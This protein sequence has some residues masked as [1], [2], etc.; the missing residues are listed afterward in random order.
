M[1]LDVDGLLKKYTAKGVL[2]DTNLLV[3]LLVGSVNKNRITRFKRTQAFTTADFDLLL[4]LIQ[5]L[6]PTIISTSHI[7]SQASDLADLKGEEL[8][9]VRAFMKRLVIET[10]EEHR[11]PAKELAA[12]PLFARL[13][14]GDAGIATVCAKNVL[15]ITTDV[16]LWS[17]IQT[18]GLD[19]INFNHI[20]EIGRGVRELRS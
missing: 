14:L 19:A 3:L 6:G 5:H 12:H 16:E 11:D 2:I 9:R 13:G 18:V 10:I 17:E 15:V 4:N 8:G 20:S 7:L 1:I